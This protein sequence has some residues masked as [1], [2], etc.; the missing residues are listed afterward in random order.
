[1]GHAWMWF[2]P[3]LRTTGTQIC[4]WIAAEVVLVACSACELHSHE[5]EALQLKS[6][7]NHDKFGVTFDCLT[8]MHLRLRHPQWQPLWGADGTGDL[9]LLGG[10][11]L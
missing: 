11:S 7:A 4:A 2:P 8:S 1:M 5:H 9:L 3:P 10:T 6:I